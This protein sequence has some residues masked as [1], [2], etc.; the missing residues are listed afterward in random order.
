MGM[1]LV[2]GREEDITRGEEMKGKEER[3]GKMS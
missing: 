1:G 2:L 3:K